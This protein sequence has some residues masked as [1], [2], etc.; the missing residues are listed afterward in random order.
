MF[1]LIIMEKL[2]R[3]PEIYWSSNSVFVYEQDLVYQ[4]IIPD[5]K[6]NFRIVITKNLLET[7][8]WFYIG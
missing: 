8:K 5:Q 4:D 1:C 7:M 2:S 3:L 6:V